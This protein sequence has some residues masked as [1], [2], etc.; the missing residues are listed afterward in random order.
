M[1]TELDNYQKN[2]NEFG[3]EQVLH[4]QFTTNHGHDDF[5]IYWH[6]QYGILLCLDTYKGKVND[7]KAYFNWRINDQSIE[8]DPIKIGYFNSKKDIHHQLKHIC[9]EGS[10]VTPWEKKPHLWLLHHGDT[11]TLRDKLRKGGLAYERTAY[12]I[13]TQRIQMLP[14]EVR[15]AMGFRLTR[16]L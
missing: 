15:C 6:K 2:I 8:D 7:S 16:P 3:F 14:E 1:E 10:F 12:D 13:N 9:N 5:Y 4:L 11:S